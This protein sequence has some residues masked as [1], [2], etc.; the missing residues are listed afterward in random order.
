ML[1]P[2]P[3]TSMSM[4]AP[5]GKRT[6]KECPTSVPLTGPQGPKSNAGCPPRL[7]V[8]VLQSGADGTLPPIKNSSATVSGGVEK[9]EP[10]SLGLGGRSGEEATVT[11]ARPP[12]YIVWSVG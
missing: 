12:S 6:A 1:G 11:T 3:L 4:C 8:A 10:E 9:K 2:R 7:K 5:S